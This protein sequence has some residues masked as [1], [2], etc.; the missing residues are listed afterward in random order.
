M[1]ADRG[2]VLSGTNP[3]FSG[4]DDERTWQST[5]PV[6]QA[7]TSGSGDIELGNLHLASHK[8]AE[9]LAA[10]QRRAEDLAKR[11]AAY[12]AAYPA[13]NDAAEHI[14]EAK[15]PGFIMF[16]RED[17]CVINFFKL[18]CYILVGP[19]VLLW[20]AVESIP[21]CIN[22]CFVEPICAVVSF[23][24]LKISKCI[25]AI[26][27]VIAECCGHILEIFVIPCCK[28]IY[29]CVASAYK[30]MNQYVFAPIVSVVPEDTLPRALRSTSQARRPIHRQYQCVVAVCTAIY[31]CLRAIASALYEHII[32][33]LYGCISA[34]CSAI[35]KGVSKC[36]TAIISCFNAFVI[37]PVYGC[38]SWFC[39]L[40]WWCV[41]SIGR[42]VKDYILLPIYGCISAIATAVRDYILV[43]IYEGL[44]AVA[45]AIYGNVLAPIGSCIG[46]VLSSIG[47]V[48][49]AILS[50]IGGVI[51]AILSAIGS[52]IS[53]LLK[54]ISD[55][56]SS[57][58]GGRRR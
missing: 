39:G 12:D 33:P 27:S 51:G 46:T 45:T 53:A 15:A 13:P 49:W 54:G 31:S 35:Y 56:I 29:A 43:P 37:S 3:M 36:C 42:A 7:V 44:S 6:A 52:A 24:C 48:I 25:T 8:T 5:V 23:I 22:K 2:P 1:A 17:G 10:E 9:Q 32:S 14:E 4:Q 57:I 20:K 34:C 21:T 38:V 19:F 30:I 18:I 55:A 16:H 40:L 58:F 41:C 26:C 47:G 50:A 28:A 11:W